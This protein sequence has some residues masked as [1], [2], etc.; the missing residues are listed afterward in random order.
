MKQNVSRALRLGLT[1]LILV[2]LV[3]FATKVNWHQIGRGIRDASRPMLFAAAL[4]NI[5]S[6]IVKAVR[7]WVFLRPIG[8]TSLPLAMRATFAG[9]GLNNVLVANGGEAARVVFVSRSA[10]IPSARVLAT[11]ALER[12][13]ELVGYAILLSL[14]ATFLQLPHS[15]E[16]VKPFAIAILAGMLA[17]L[18]WLLRRPDVV[19]N[20]AV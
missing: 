11:L 18:V 2:F 14:A 9:A 19:A 16:R 5:A 4:V 3:I 20:V 6:I 8:A 7:W 1:L 17:L 15:L 12:L 13:F 10:H